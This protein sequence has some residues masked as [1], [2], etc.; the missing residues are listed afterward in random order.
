[1]KRLCSKEALRNWVSTAAVCITWPES[2]LFPAEKNCWI[3]T[4]W[5]GCGFDTR[6]RR[7]STTQ[8]RLCGPF[9]H[10][11]VFALFVVFYLF[12]RE[13]LVAEGSFTWTILSP[14]VGG[15]QDKRRRYRTCCRIT[16]CWCRSH[17]A[18]LPSVTN[19][20]PG[21]LTE[22]SM[23]SG[24]LDTLKQICFQWSQPANTRVCVRACV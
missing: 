16:S 5:T 15:G 24:C 14:G 12:V 10:F 20:E 8:L 13:K 19:R 22:P 18:L 2:P 11:A 4:E 17:G 6:P 21:R 1:M 23:L 7:V 3:V 9:C